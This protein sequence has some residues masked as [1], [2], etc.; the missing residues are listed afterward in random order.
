M[1][2]NRIARAPPWQNEA[3]S[4][5]IA[6]V[7]SGSVRDTPPPEP[8]RNSEWCGQARVSGGSGPVPRRHLER[9]YVARA[10]SNGSLP[11]DAAQRPRSRPSVELQSWGRSPERFPSYSPGDEESEDTFL[12]SDAAQPRAR[13][14]PS[15]DSK[16][17]RTSQPHAAQKGPVRSQHRT[18][19]KKEP[20]H[21]CKSAGR[22]EVPSSKSR[23][24]TTSTRK[25]NVISKAVNNIVS[26]HYEFNE[27]EAE[28]LKPHAEES[29]VDGRFVRRHGSRSEVVNVC[30]NRGQRFSQSTGPPSVASLDDLNSEPLS[31]WGTG[32]TTW[33]PDIGTFTIAGRKRAHPQWINQDAQLT[34]ELADGRW[35]IAVFDGHGE[36][37]HYISSRACNLF[38]EI[39]NYHLG[40]GFGDSKD[41][42]D[43]LFAQTQAV[44]ASEGLCNLSGTT[45]SC[46][47][48][49][50]DAQ[51]VV[52]AHV[53]DSTML[54]AKNGDVLHVTCDHKFDAETEQRIQAWGGEIRDEKGGRRIFSRGG[55]GPGLAVGRALGDLDASK[56]GLLSKPEISP[57]LSFG[58]GYAIT[59]ASDGVWDMISCEEA[60]Q[61]LLDA[62]DPQTAAEYLATDARKEW[63]V[64]GD[65]DDITA[66][67]I[68]LALF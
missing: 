23:F 46:A 61:I 25:Q 64:H 37:G 60:A 21:G 8:Q 18:S 10:N 55:I 34:K 30:P 29:Y 59:V 42:F 20:G 47:V 49:D 1:S 56:L 65:I 50:V 22:D 68:E 36:Y 38:D 66:V 3:T 40:I 4:A 12:D 24:G 26:E 44:L 41:N 19:A 51:T 52:F 6:E 27:P 43:G 35:L 57:V 13:Q 39:A 2:S 16:P 54:L 9:R 48:I 45:A 17:R 53:G 58:P 32:S 15:L 67:V 28:P 63:L 33:R 31:P 62:E 7:F 5:C 14:R 11:D